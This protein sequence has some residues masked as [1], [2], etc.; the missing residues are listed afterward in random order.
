MGDPQELSV[1]DDQESTQLA[2]PPPKAPDPPPNGGLVAWLQVLGGFFIFFNSW[3]VT[4]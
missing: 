2:S 3:F 4:R 1:K